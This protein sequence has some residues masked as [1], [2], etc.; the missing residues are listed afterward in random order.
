MAAETLLD[1]IMSLATTAATM[2]R[3]DLSGAV[4]DPV[5]GFPEKPGDAEL[6]TER[7]NNG[8]V[9]MR[10]MLAPVCDDER[11]VEAV[12]KVVCA[13]L[14]PNA[15]GPWVIFGAADRPWTVSMAQSV[16]QEN[17]GDPQVF[18]DAT[19]GFQPGALMRLG[20]GPEDKML[21]RLNYFRQKPL[22]VLAHAMDGATKIRHERILGPQAL[23][24]RELLNLA[25]YHDPHDVQRRKYSKATWS[26]LRGDKHTFVTVPP[27]GG[28]C[29]LLPDEF[30]ASLIPAHVPRALSKSESAD[31]QRVT[32]WLRQLAQIRLDPRWAHEGALSEAINKA[33][34]GNFILGL[35]GDPAVRLYNVLQ[36][37]HKTHDG[38]LRD[39][40]ALAAQVKELDSR[41]Q[42]REA[43]FTLLRERLARAQASERELRA[44]IR[45]KDH[46]LE[47]LRALDPERLE[48]ERDEAVEALEHANSLLADATAEAE[49]L[50]T[51]LAE[52]EGR[53]E[54]EPESWYELFQ[55]AGDFEYVDVPDS[56]LQPAWK[57]L[58]RGQESGLWLRRTWAVLRR[59]ED[60][61]RAK[62]A[63]A[64]G[65][66]YSN[67]KLFA[68]A[69]PVRFVTGTTVTLNE[70]ATVRQ[71]PKMAR[72]RTFNTPI[73]DVFMEEHAA[74][75]SG[76][77]PAPRLHYKD[78]TNGTTGRIYVGYV[79]PHLENT[80][81][82]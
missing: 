48:L 39:F 28:M 60:Y 15:H 75:G 16:L 79:G 44:T 72:A 38:M 17:L 25:V 26:S 3:I 68:T 29:L 61:A 30:D 8:R 46:D 10:T 67:F 76:R 4:T 12:A 9:I 27:A 11:K 70:S 53:P 59:L 18:E 31:A 37:A 42:E 40:Q 23:E 65:V 58:D 57:K 81:T 22:A 51:R 14:I 80:L 82:N 52:A 54:R 78:D 34:H 24:Y 43:T 69:F 66:E 63:G 49:R 6:N 36:E 55:L 33:N 50:R 20:P 13:V 7:L 45:A 35:S 5:A 19:G 56:A 77:P 74:I 2:H 64:S 41:E 47:R 21:T 32:A 71:D 73:G 1:K 62:A